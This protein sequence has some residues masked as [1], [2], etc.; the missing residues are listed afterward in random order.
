MKMHHRRISRGEGLVEE[1]VAEG[2]LLGVGVGL[3]GLGLGLDPGLPAQ[4]IMRTEKESR[5]SESQ[6]DLHDVRIL[7]TEVEVEV[8]VEV[9]IGMAEMAAGRKSSCRTTRK[10]TILVAAA[11][12]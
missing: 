8:E 12:M 1:A 7:E 4:V 11:V 5:R 6:R 2:L 3:V 9:E 10:T